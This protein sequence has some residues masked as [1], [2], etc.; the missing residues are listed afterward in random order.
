MPP[1]LFTP[2]K[3]RNHEIEC[4][5]TNTVSH[6]MDEEA[7][8]FNVDLYDSNSLSFVY[9]RIAL[10]SWLIYTKQK[11]PISH[12]PLFFV[13]LVIE[14]RVMYIRG[15]HSATD[16]LS[17]PIYPLFFIPKFWLLSFFIP[18]L[19]EMNLARTTVS[20]RPRQKV[21]RISSQSW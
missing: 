2:F 9:T 15:K 16:P 10:L 5:M 8:V 7:L 12:S 17:N 1:V 3:M 11:F 6:S 19:F 21:S 13:G 20:G 18:L 4:L 14:P